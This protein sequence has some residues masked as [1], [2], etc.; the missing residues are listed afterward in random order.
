MKILSIDPGTTTGLCFGVIEANGAL[1]VNPK[2]ERLLASGFWR[3]LEGWEPE[4]LICE[5][6]EFRKGSRQGLVLDSVKFIGIAELYAQLNGAKLH[7]QMA[8][9][10]KSYYSDTKL[11]ALNIYV[12][13]LPHGMD[14]LRHLLH[15]FTFGP[16]FRFNQQKELKV[17]F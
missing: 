13:G 1:V 16:G 6:F 12:S 7:G 17:S 5:S 8:A 4:E 3:V 11:K 9:H 15:W 2:Q 14:A 10:G